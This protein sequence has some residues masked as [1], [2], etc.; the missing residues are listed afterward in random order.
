[1]RELAQIDRI[2]RFMLELGKVARRPTRVYFTGGAC[3]VMLGW[4]TSTIDL[5]LH[6]VPDDDDLLREVPHLKELLNVNVELACPADFLPEVPGWADRSVF[7]RT[8]GGVS[9]YHYD[10]YAQALSKIERD[11]QKDRD[12]VAAMIG[13]GLVEPAR[14]MLL[15]EAIEPEL[16]RFPAVDP[17]G[18]RRRV[19]RVASGRP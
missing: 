11:H 14:L 17:P 3:A 18:L 16:F 12:D 2:E 1:M 13:E 5:D 15:F 10:F 4:R 7:I 19:E 6:F 9:F 8:V